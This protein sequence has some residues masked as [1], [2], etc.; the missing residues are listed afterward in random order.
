[1]SDETK[2]PDT[3]DHEVADAPE[4]GYW[5]ISETCEHNCLGLLILALVIAW[6]GV[7]YVFCCAGSMST[8]C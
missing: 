6:V 2:Q 5:V 1:M 4:E 7:V 8:V 3:P